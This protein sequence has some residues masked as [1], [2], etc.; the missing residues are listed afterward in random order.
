MLQESTGKREREREREREGGREGGKE[1]GS[2]GC[3]HCNTQVLSQN[4]TRTNLFG[5]VSF[6]FQAEEHRGRV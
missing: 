5:M 3:L 2:G 6:L 1:G 4:Q